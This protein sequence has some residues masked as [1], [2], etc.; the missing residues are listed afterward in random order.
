MGENVELLKKI[1]SLSTVNGEIIRRIDAKV[2]SGKVFFLSLLKIKIIRYSYALAEGP[3]ST[4][5]ETERIVSGKNIFN[6]LTW[7]VS[8]NNGNQIQVE[9]L[10]NGPKR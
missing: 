4:I 5:K 6:I 3:K 7:K 1:S 2:K 8:S 9:D 10:Y